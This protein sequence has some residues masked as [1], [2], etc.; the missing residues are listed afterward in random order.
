MS[1][2]HESIILKSRAFYCNNLKKKKITIINHCRSH[3]KGS[4]LRSK[5]IQ[6][7]GPKMKPTRHIQ[8]GL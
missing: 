6:I 4:L 8:F 2:M 7:K 5:L 1:G 3:I